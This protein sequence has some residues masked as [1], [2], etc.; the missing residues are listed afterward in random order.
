MNEIQSFINNHDICV[1]ACIES[2]QTR[3]GEQ[4]L[5]FWFQFESYFSKI[6]V[7]IL[8]LSRDNVQVCEKMEI[9]FSTS[10]LF[11]HDNEDLFF[12]TNRVIKRKLVFGTEKEIVYPYIFVY[13][14]GKEIVQI[15]RMNEKSI[16][17][18]FVFVLKIQYQRF[19]KN[20]KNMF[21]I[22]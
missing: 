16:A 19:L 12:M 4:Y 6:Q 8:L 22:P 5:D 1:I 9:M 18:L 15:K 20:F 10:I 13:K 11:R 17:E 3:K 21:D 2:F 14:D 7:P